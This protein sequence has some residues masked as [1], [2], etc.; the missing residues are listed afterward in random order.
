MNLGGLV[1]TF[2]LLQ[3]NSKNFG[4]FLFRKCI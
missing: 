3:D 2:L 1:G 4:H